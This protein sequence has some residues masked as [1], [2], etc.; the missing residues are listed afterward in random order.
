MERNRIDHF[1]KRE[2]SGAAVIRQDL[3]TALLRAFFEE[4]AS[5]GY[6]SISLERVATRAGAGKAA[7][8]RRWSSKLV[9]A[10]EALSSVQ[11]MRLNAADQGSLSADIREHLRATRIALRHPLAR[12]I[13]P[14]LLAERHRTPELDAL[15]ERGT[16]ARRAFGHKLLDRAIARQ[17]LRADLDRELALDLI[18]STVFT[19]MAVQRRHFTKTEFERLIVAVVAA[20]KTC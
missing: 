5:A 19:R 13:I 15:V 20:V 4:W 14:D 17:E 16:A 12:R 7:I 8:Y 9:L 11:I 6:A 3:T 1:R 2:A 10:C 18:F